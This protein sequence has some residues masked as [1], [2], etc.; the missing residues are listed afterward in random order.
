MS[1]SICLTNKEKK[2]EREERIYSVNEKYDKFD[3]PIYEQIKGMIDMS[4][5]I[6]FIVDKLIVNEKGNFFTV[7]NWK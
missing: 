2:K 3:K 6:N 5:A 7:K 4:R 1:R